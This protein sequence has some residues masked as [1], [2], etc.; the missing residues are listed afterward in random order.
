M[1]YTNCENVV[2]I[3]TH[4][5]SVIA[6]YA[7]CDLVWQRGVGPGSW[8]VSWTPTDISGT[9][10]MFGSE[11]QAS[12]YNGYYSWSGLSSGFIPGN[13][14]YDPSVGKGNFT[15]M[16]GMV[17]METNVKSI[18]DDTFDHIYTLRTAS[19]SRC[20][21]I[22]SEAF[23][24]CSSLSYVYMPK[25]RYISDFAFDW[26]TSLTSIYAPSCVEVRQNAFY[27]CDL[28]TLDLPSCKT[29]SVGAFAGNHNLSQVSL[30]VCEQIWDNAFDNCYALQELDLP[31]CQWVAGIHNCSSLSRVNLPVAS[32]CGFTDCP[33]LVD[34]SVPNAKAV[35][36][37]GC[38]NLSYISLPECE[39]LYGYDARPWPSGTGAF[40]G[41]THLRSIEVPK[42]VSMT[43]FAF[44]SCTLLSY[45]DLG[46]V[47][48]IN[49]QT[50][51]DCVN[52]S[53]LILRN[54]SVVLIEG[55]QF[56]SSSIMES[57]FHNTP[58]W[59]C[60]GAVYVPTYLYSKYLNDPYWSYVSCAIRSMFMPIPSGSYYVSWTP[61]TITGAFKI[62]GYT[63]YYQDYTDG[64]VWFIGGV[65]ESSA[66]RSGTFSSFET[67]A[68]RFESNAFR[69]CT[70]LASLS[71][72][73][74]EYVGYACFSG[75]SE[76]RTI[77]LPACTSVEDYA[78][79]GCYASEID[80]SVCVSIPE[81]TLNISTLISVN[82]P[83]LSYLDG[84][85][86]N[87]CGKLSD[88]RLPLCKYVGTRAFS[89]CSMLSVIDLPMCEEIDFHAF[90]GCSSLS[91]I[92][93]P[94]CKEIH[95]SCF[96][97]CYNLTSIDLPAC[98][99][100]GASVF[101]SR[102]QTIILRASSVCYLTGNLT[103]GSFTGSIYVPSSLYSGYTYQWSRYRGQIYS[104]PEP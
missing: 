88:V 20:I 60:Q 85:T 72:P 70:S 10:W 94:L 49:D 40:D 101:T 28:R 16:S 22:D 15:G 84:Y 33:S 6:V 2:G 37:S 97:G 53:T 9:F 7:Y 18:G 99:S 8:Y 46:S 26:C 3:Y 12:D 31:V 95:L 61:T 43:S 32:A 35:C 54:S 42:L 93:L 19:L 100:L 86:F 21:Y 104:I 66:Y 59:N 50:F 11:Y 80:L 57:M 102:L 78:F 62:D 98:T 103:V 5:E 47:S 4:C 83:V 25:V 81:G 36:F 55:S 74:C 24:E 1:I 17:Y 38:T 79:S 87:N 63:Q 76:L 29:I 23:R 14:S 34:V 48:I 27:Q 90:D 41:C 92:S 96:R 77:S 30:P 64:V 39:T 45:A 58:I 71:A 73:N 67:N 51:Y 56:Y 75:C 65:I 89:G 91:S 68:Y 82:L 44:R 69:G 13:Y 52:L